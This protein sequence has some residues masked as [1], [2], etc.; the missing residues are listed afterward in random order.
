M[1]KTLEEIR[2]SYIQELFVFFATEY[3]RM[4]RSNHSDLN[5]FRN[6]LADKI[7]NTLVNQVGSNLINDIRVQVSQQSSLQDRRDSIIESIIEDTEFE[8]EPTFITLYYQTSRGLEINR[9][10]VCVK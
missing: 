6:H 5:Q 3:T 1:S 4:F 7:L 9:I 8:P 2:K 10:D